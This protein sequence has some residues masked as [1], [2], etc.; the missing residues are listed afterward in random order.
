MNQ[1]ILIDKLRGDLAQVFPNHLPHEFVAPMH[2]YDV[3]KCRYCH[4]VRRLQ[5]MGKTCPKRVK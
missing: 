1:I 2:Q 4:V 5:L 3:P